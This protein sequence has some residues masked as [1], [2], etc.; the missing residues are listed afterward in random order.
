MEV[1]TCQTT[2]H[3]RDSKNR[4]GPRLDAALAIWSTFVAYAQQG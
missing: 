1:A 2:I 3:I 4:R